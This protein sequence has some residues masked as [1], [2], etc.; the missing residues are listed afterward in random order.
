[1]RIHPGDRLDRHHEVRLRPHVDRCPRVVAASAGSGI[2]AAAAAAAGSSAAATA[3]AAAAA[4]AAIVAAGTATAG[5]LVASD[6]ECDT[7]GQQ[8]HSVRY[9]S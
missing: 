3:S 6:A 9:E 1:M 2:A 5:Q 4:A 7:D 8:Q